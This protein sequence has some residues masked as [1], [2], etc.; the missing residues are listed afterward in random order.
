MKI[1][2]GGTRVVLVLP[3]FVIKIPRIRPLLGLWRLGKR[4]FKKELVARLKELEQPRQK[5][6]KRYFL[7]GFIANRQELAY[8]KAH[9]NSPG[10]SPVY[11][12]CFGLIEIQRRGRAITAEN[13]QWKKLLS[14]FKR[15]EF[16]EK[17]DLLRFQNFSILKGKIRIHDYGNEH[18]ISALNNG[19]LQLLEQFA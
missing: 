6:L 9:R 11:M 3:Y 7:E 18:T 14:L 1:K 8:Y 13:S 12:A 17:T 5:I 19:A 16:D 15:N 2:V 10:I 4:L